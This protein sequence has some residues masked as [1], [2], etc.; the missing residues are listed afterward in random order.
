MNAAVRPHAPAR[1]EAAP[2]RFQSLPP[3]VGPWQPLH[4]LS[5]GAWYRVWRA[6]PVDAPGDDSADY[7][8]KV[9]DAPPRQLPLAQQMLRR[10]AA[11]G[12]AVCSPHV[13][14]VLASQTGEAPAYL[15]MPHLEGATLREVIDSGCH[16]PA[17]HAV[18]VVR[19][20]AQGLAALHDH[21]WMHAD[22]KPENIH[23]SADGH[24]KL[25][26]LGYARRTGRAGGAWQRMF[27]GT[28]RYTA[29]E[30]LAASPADARSDLY[31]LGAVLYELL[32]GRPPLQAPDAR[33][34]V[35]AHLERR[36][37]PLRGLRPD[38][39]GELCRLVAQLLAKQPLRRPHSAHDLVDRLRRL[40]IDALAAASPL[41][42]PAA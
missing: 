14:T 23:V 5:Q 12:R 24:A 30:R 35:V 34:L 25:L 40:E 20:I 8:V 2:R 42:G 26:D 38:L 31:S 6:R 32:S 10:E 28:L 16:V 1:A 9:A 36:P 3:A 15:V 33:R 41:N 22:V 21:G 19:Q 17:P 13:V 39:P 18:W 27:C 37:A 11:L 29:P 7:V 4:C